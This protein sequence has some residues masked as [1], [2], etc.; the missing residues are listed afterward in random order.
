MNSQLSQEDLIRNEYEFWK[1]NSPILYELVVS[2][3]LEWPS[4]TVEWLP[5]IERYVIS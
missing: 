5:L 1:K 3:A 4:L 2:Q